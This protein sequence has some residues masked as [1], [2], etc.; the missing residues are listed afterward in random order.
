MT[1]MNSIKEALYQ[2]DAD[3]VFKLT[4][5]A[6]KEGISAHTIL[7]DG[8]IGGMNIVGVD[9][10]DGEL[11]IPEVLIAAQAMKSG[12]EVLKPLLAEA[13][14]PSEGKIVLGTVQ[15]DLHDIGKNLVGMMMEGAGF[16]VYDLGIDIP[17]EKF[18]AAVKEQK[19][20]LVGLSALLTTSMPMMKTTIEA[21]KQTSLRA[22]IM[23]GGA[24]VTQEYA[25][26]IDADGYA[27]NAVSAVDRAKQLLEK[28]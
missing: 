3:L 13:D 27:S 9:F 14:T 22:K 19:P 5:Q 7:T 26:S 24:P 2:G 11:F 21:I 25:N 18:V 8:L 16:I 28:N 17:P 12:M 20:D 23:I 4:N 6:L 15:G 10:K 1:E